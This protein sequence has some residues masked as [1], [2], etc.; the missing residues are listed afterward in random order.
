MK[1]TSNP[2]F[3]VTPTRIEPIDAE[4]ALLRIAQEFMTEHSLSPEN[5]ENQEDT[6]HIIHRY[7]CFLADDHLLTED[8]KITPQQQG[9]VRGWFINI[10][11]GSFPKAENNTERAGILFN[12][13]CLKSIAFAESPS[14]FHEESFEQTRD[15]TRKTFRENFS[16]V[17]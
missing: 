5:P 2:S 13:L 16:S 3:T 11:K 9:Q 15:Q 12:S 17:D 4:V 14:S 10:I 6:S 7:M 1:V 8:A